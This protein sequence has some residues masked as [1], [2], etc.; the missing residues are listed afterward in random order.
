MCVCVCVN[1]WLRYMVKF[2]NTNMLKDNF[3]NSYNF[4][5]LFRDISNFNILSIDS[6]YKSIFN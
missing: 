6:I 5:I 3:S 4:K 1:V 2:T